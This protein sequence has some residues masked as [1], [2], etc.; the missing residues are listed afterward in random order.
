MKATR[1]VVFAVSVAV[2]LCMRTAGAP[3][4]R[5]L[6]LVI[7]EQDQDDKTREVDLNIDCGDLSTEVMD[8]VR[9]GDYRELIALA[10]SMSRM[11]KSS[12]AVDPL[13]TS[14]PRSERS[15]IG[16]DDRLPVDDR[17]RSSH[18]Y[19]ALGELEGVGCTAAFIG[20][21]HALTAAHCVYNINTDS[22]NTNLDLWRGRTCNS[23]GVRMRY[24]NEVYVPEGYS[25]WHNSEYDFALILYEETS[26]CTLCFGYHS[27]WP[28]HGF[29]IIGY[30][31]DK[32]DKDRLHCSY[33][34]M[35][36]SSCHYSYALGSSRFQYRCDT[37]PGNSGSP[38]LSQ[39]PGDVEG[40][41]V[42]YGVHTDGEISTY[43]SGT[44]ITKTRFCAFVKWMSRNGHVAMCG[45]E[46][47]CAENNGSQGVTCFPPDTTV[48][49]EGSAG[50]G[51]KLMKDLKVGDR[52]LST[53]ATG[54]LVYSPVIALLHKSPKTI[55][56]YVKITTENNKHLLTPSHLLFRHKRSTGSLDTSEAVFASKIQTGDYVFSLSSNKSIVAERVNGISYVDIKGA[57]GPLT[58]EGTLVV[59]NM[60][61]SCYAVIE[62]HSMLHML[63]APLRFLYSWSPG[64]FSSLDEQNDQHW[65][66]HLL[67][68]VGHYIHP[69]VVTENERSSTFYELMSI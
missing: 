39:R 23:A 56:T 25:K 6:H 38:L 58:E 24:A 17:E 14:Q 65:Y 55:M 51:S 13:P 3:N 27:N 43:N 46:P 9:G 18:P 40:S 50:A 49:V 54:E 29:D 45:G 11:N 62:N 69:Y 26:P 7:D 8:T 10:K 35:F 60:A 67:T 28:N 19:C 53:T 30:P 33:D 61:T 12:D 42:V 37:F 59:N 34:S 22:Y 48:M 36:F 15:I 21:R 52:V 4:V 57:Y 64:L 66:T 1:T 63:F 47:C 20:P 32:D 31:G 16:T 41:R 44:R 2:I 5:K 68:G